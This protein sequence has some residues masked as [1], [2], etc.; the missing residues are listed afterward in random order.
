MISRDEKLV[1]GK[2]HNNYTDYFQFLKFFLLY[3]VGLT[4]MHLPLNIVFKCGFLFYFSDKR[5]K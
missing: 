2:E 3:I 1:S 4:F 5:N